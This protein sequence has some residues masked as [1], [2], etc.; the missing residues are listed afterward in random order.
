MNKL[1]VLM[2]GAAGYISSQ[3]IPAFRERYD[4]ILLDIKQ[5]S[6]RGSINEIIKVDLTDPDIEKYRKYFKGVDAIVHNAFRWKKECDSMAP[7]QWL[8]RKPGL[9]FSNPDAYYL[10]RE[11]IDM[12]FHI[13]TLAL[14][15][16]IRRVVVTSSNHAA[17]WYETKLHSGKMDYVD[18]ETCPLS[19]NLYGWAKATYEHLGFVFATGRFGRP[20]ENIHIRIGA[21]RPIVGADLKEDQI[22]FRRD[23]GA[24]ISERDLQ[25]LYIKSI[26]T[27]NI[28]RE[29][30][31]PFQIFYGISNNTRAFWS[32]VNAR[33]V[34]GYEPIDDSEQLFAEDINK[35]L[36]SGGR[37]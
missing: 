12:V 2:T 15:E 22:H 16:N 5:E 11:N 8:S 3:L 1:K 7:L 18:A 24:F 33:R 32:I 13:L 21:P 31:V 30:G 4:L 17:D 25:Q 27:R 14:K 29:D 26:E 36:K 6:P 37:T 28:R 19:N 20:L 35:Y 34:I 10:E 9:T 23:L